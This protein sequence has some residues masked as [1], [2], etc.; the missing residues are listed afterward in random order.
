MG[1]GSWRR[2]TTWRDDHDAQVGADQVNIQGVGAEQLSFALE[3]LEQNHSVWLKAVRQ[4][5]RSQSLLHGHV[6]S[7]DLRVAQ[8]TGTLQAPHHCNAW[9]AI[10]REGEHHNGYW[11]RIGSQHSTWPSNHDRNIGIW[12]WRT[13]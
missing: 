3:K 9:G 10:F 12:C 13:R 5:A 7:D 1:Q 6:T 4:Y 2:G 11:K 8:E